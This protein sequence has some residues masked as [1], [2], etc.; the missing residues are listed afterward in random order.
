MPNLVPWVLLVAGIVVLLISLSG[1]RAGFS[2][3]AL[4]EMVGGAAAVLCGLR[5]RRR[6]VGASKP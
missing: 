6:L 3:I 4:L 1:Q 2:W 5:W